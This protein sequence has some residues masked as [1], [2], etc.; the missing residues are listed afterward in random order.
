MY[1]CFPLSCDAA[2]TYNNDCHSENIS[3]MWTEHGRHSTRLYGVTLATSINFPRRGMC[4][5]WLVVS[6][7]LLTFVDV[8]VNIMRLKLS[9]ATSLPCSSTRIYMHWSMIAYIMTKWKR[10]R[11]W[12]IEESS[13]GWQL[14]ASDV[15]L[16]SFISCLKAPSVNLINEKSGTWLMKV[17]WLLNWPGKWMCTT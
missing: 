5:V 4:F 7:M 12:K 1:F 9:C 3:K 8:S 13:F 16:Y 17:A 10:V 14:K 6:R 15:T 2:N 11:N